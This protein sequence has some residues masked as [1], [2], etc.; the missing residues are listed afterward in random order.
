[1]HPGLGL[2]WS[3]ANLLPHL[4]PARPV[5]TLQSPALL[6]GVDGLPA[7]IGAMAD[8]YL[9]RVRELQPRGP[10]LLLGRSFGGP[11]AHELAVR[12]RRSGEEVRMLAVVDA[13][14]MPE[15][16]LDTPLEPAAVEDEMLRILLHSHAPGAPVPDGPLDRATVFST[17]HEGAFDGLSEAAL[18]TLVDIGA[19]HSALVRTWRP[20]RYGGGLTLFSATHD[21]W[22]G[23]AEKTAAWR[24][25]TASLD[26]HELDCGHSDVLNPGPAAEIAAVLENALRGD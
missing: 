6:T 14:P 3:Y 13:M 7:S 1:M 16:I 17:A 22:P 11:L 26:V 20:N 9:P 15:E 10:Y 21:S 2:G 4:D 12:L 19:H 18:H 25:V 5:H 24:R 8:L 23:T